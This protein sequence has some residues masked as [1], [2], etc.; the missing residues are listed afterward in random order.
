MGSYL[1]AYQHGLPY[2]LG[3]SAHMAETTSPAVRS[4]LKVMTSPRAK[5]SFYWLA[6]GPI[7]DYLRPRAGIFSE[8][9]M[10]RLS[11]DNRP[12]ARSNHS[13]A[14]DHFYR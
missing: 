7:T 4:I 11:M 12:R 14:W 6:S 1:S 9:H 5:S 3:A 2:P 8:S 10:D 13:S